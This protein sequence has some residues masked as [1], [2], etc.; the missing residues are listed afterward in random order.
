MQCDCCVVRAVSAAVH[1]R[2][3]AAAQL[4]HHWHCTTPKGRALHAGAM[5]LDAAQ[6]ETFRRD[7][8]LLL[9]GLISAEQIAAWRDEFFYFQQAE[10]GDPE[11]W[12]GAPR[13]DPA[14][15]RGSK[16]F[17]GSGGTFRPGCCRPATGSLVELP[18]VKAVADQLAGEHGW[19][20]EFPFDGHAVCN[21]PPQQS[22]AEPTSESATRAVQEWQPTAKGHLDGYG[23]NGWIGGFNHGFGVCTYLCGGAAERSGCFTYW[24]GSHRHT[25]QFFIENPELIDGSE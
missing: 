23:S 17:A 20:C 24:P 6:I 14:A 1:E 19:A 12:P 2:Y 9:R 18:E 7:G 8:V 4:S 21:W 25:H 11:S 13:F 5:P 10:P 15:S 3:S 16:H 22:S